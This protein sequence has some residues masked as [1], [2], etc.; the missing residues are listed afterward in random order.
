MGVAPLDTLHPSQRLVLCRMSGIYLK[1]TSAAPPARRGGSAGTGRMI[2]ACLPF[3]IGAAHLG[4]AAQ[5]AAEALDV[6]RFNECLSRVD[7]QRGYVHV[8]G[9]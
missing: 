2:E 6:Q 5:A 4:A 9:D 1:S 3:Q 7:P 8:Q